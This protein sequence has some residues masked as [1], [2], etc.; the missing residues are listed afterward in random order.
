MLLFL[1]LQALAGEGR[2]GRYARGKASLT[3]RA[4]GRMQ[5][6]RPDPLFP[7]R[8]GS[9]AKEQRGEGSKQ[10]PPAGGGARTTFQANWLN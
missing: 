10:S 7:R 5:G 2:A 4:P 8:K 1:R 3:N 9:R 6:E